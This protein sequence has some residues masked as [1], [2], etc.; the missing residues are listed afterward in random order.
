MDVSELY[1][2]R[3]DNR[4]AA[5]PALA[6]ALQAVPDHVP[7]MRLLAELQA[8]NRQWEEA[9][10]LLDRVLELS[11]D[12]TTVCAT[13]MALARMFDEQLVEPKRAIEHAAAVLEIDATHQGA[14]DRMMAIQAK[15]GDI[16]AAVNTARQL[17][18]VSSGTDG[19]PPAL[20][21][22]ARLERKHG[23]PEAALNALLDAVLEDGPQGKAAADLRDMI[24]HGHGD[25][26]MYADVVSAYLQ[27]AMGDGIDRAAAYLDLARVQ[28]DRLDDLDSA[29]STLQTGVDET[30]GQKSLVNKHS[31]QARP[32]S[33]D[34]N[35]LR[36]IA[37]NGALSTPGAD[38]M[39][40]LTPG[41]AK[42]HP[43]NLESL[44][45]SKRDR[46][47]P[48]SPHA[49]RLIVDELAATF[50]IEE[51]DLYEHMLPEPLVAVEA[52]DPPAI[53]ISERVATLPETMQVFLLGHAFSSLSGNCYPVEKLSAKAVE[54][55]LTAAA[56]S[57][58]PSFS[59]NAESVRDLDDYAQQ[60][61]KAIPR[62]SRKQK[63][64]LA[65][66]YVASPCTDFASW[67]GAVRQ[68]T[69]RAALLLTDD[70]V[71]SID[72]I[73]QSD[74]ELKA[75]SG[76]LLVQRSEMIA[77]LLRFWMSDRAMAF[78]RRAGLLP[79]GRA[80]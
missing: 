55:L 50:S 61:H 36:T 80:T 69:L 16:Q 78:R 53:V 15:S 75:M 58:V 25:W 32:G 2:K 47:P 7:T 54:R 14:L 46:V 76:K 56:H 33:F 71:T 21:R 37:M 9:I 48:R 43:A 41:M 5:A 10:K 52:T 73:R 68:T 1:S 66:R 3:L 12:Q 79:I 67:T 18:D 42:L 24:E 44:G 26:S 70:L 11:S 77:D 57:V 20:R 30:G 63:E 59:G 74:K 72:L 4:G 19:H 60:I 40:I 38:L 34:N 49:M 17:V 6:R 64:E 29:L 39:T 31:G 13:H 51:Y 27:E 62:K 45:L 35:A 28:A 65:R 8:A 22:L 23:D